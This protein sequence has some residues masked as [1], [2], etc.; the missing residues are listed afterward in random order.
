MYPDDDINWEIDDVKSP[1]FNYHLSKVLSRHSNLNA[2]LTKIGI[3]I[4][5]DKLE[6]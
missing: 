2:T 3:E 1:V 6:E 4:D 5:N